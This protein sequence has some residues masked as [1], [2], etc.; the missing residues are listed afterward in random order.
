MMAQVL[1]LFPVLLVH[2][3]LKSESLPVVP[4][5]SLSE[6]FQLVLLVTVAVYSGY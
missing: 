3:N 1:V 2:V 4:E 6:V 5:Y